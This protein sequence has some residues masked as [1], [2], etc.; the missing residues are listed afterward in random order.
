MT[1]V[2]TATSR[3]R[4]Q[5]ARTRA[6]EA[7]TRRS[8]ARDQYDAALAANDQRAA[9]AAQ[10]ALDDA[11]IEMETA[12]ALRDQVLSRIAGVEGIGNSVS[13]GQ[14]PQ[15]AETLHQLAMS[16]A[17]INQQVALG[18]VMSAEE[19]VNFTGR[20][21]AVGTGTTTVPAE[22]AE[23]S[24]G[25]I[26]PTPQVP[27]DLLDYFASRGMDGRTAS[28]MRRT[29]VANAAVAPP[30]SVKL[31]SDLVYEYVEVAAEV[32]ATWIKVFRQDL[33]DIHPCRLRGGARPCRGEP[34]TS[35]DGDRDR[36]R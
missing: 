11:Q 18:E 8:R 24:F 12:D 36:L 7:R 23:G 13:F 28:F 35:R 17:P 22:S 4:L 1:A 2:V 9:A 30:G 20:A 5:V 31:A 10:I 19:F 32:V 34:A 21:L 25:G 15:V 27:I 29:G 14:D 26:T 33:D 16:S 6:N 3:E